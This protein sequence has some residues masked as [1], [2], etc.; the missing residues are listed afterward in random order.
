[1]KAVLKLKKKGNKRVYIF[2]KDENIK[3]EIT[4]DDKTNIWCMLRSKN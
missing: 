4:Q 2:K 3:R 1:M